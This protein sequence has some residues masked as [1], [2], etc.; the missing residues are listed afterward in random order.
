MICGTPN[1]LRHFIIRLSPFT[2]SYVPDVQKVLSRGLLAA[3]QQAVSS[4]VNLLTLVLAHSHPPCASPS[5]PL[6]P[7]TPTPILLTRHHQKKHNI[8]PPSCPSSPPSAR[9]SLSP[10]NSTSQDVQHKTHKNRAGYCWSIRNEWCRRARCRR[11]GLVG[12]RVAGR[13]GVCLPGG[14]VR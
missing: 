3:C 10:N 6:R 12:L 8:P 11:S 13:R 5:F 14:C 1:A 2:L 4:S 7:R 9:Q